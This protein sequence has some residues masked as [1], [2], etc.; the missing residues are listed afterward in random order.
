MMLA[1]QQ[2]EHT[3]QYPVSPVPNESAVLSQYSYLVRRAMGHVRTQIG[4][5]VGHDDLQQ[6]GLLALLNAVR[7]YGRQTDEQFESFAFKHIRGAMLDEFRRQDW[8]P[9]QL[10]QQAHRLRDAQRLLRRELGREPTD[11]EIAVQLNISQEEVTELHYA[12]AAEALESLEQTLEMGHN[13]YGMVSQGLCEFE[14]KAMLRQAMARLPARNKL[15]LHL[16]YTHELNMK[17]I[18]LTL[19]LTESRVCQL[20]KQSVEMLTQ[21]LQR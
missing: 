11:Q 6:I 12:T 15:L 3:N 5:L 19:S 7:R 10:R 2:H 17:E 4:V 13:P 18:A 21:R 20:H 16:Y 1:Q 8:R 14:Q 9:R